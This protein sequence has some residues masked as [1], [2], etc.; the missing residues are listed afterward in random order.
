MI[1]IQLKLLSELIMIRIIFVLAEISFREQSSRI[2]PMWYAFDFGRK[3]KSQ[4]MKF[5]EILRINCFMTDVS[6][7]FALQINGL[8]SM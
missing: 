4:T 1:K 3:S 8:V 2:R 5:S 7:I 6:I